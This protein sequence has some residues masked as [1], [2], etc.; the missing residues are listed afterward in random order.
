[1]SGGVFSSS[2][3]VRQVFYNSL[4]S[5]RADA[6]LNPGVIEPVRG[7]LEIARKGVGK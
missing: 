7:A 1:M 3:L 4:H 2:A 6:V 5:E